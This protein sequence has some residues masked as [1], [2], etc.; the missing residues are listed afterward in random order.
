MHVA[1]HLLASQVIQEGVQHPLQSD[2][3]L[4][5]GSVEFEQLLGV[6]HSADLIIL[7]MHNKQGHLYLPTKTK[8]AGVPLPDVLYK[9]HW[10]C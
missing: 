9:L 6:Q 1:H 2:E 10:L 5:C 4:V 3:L 8:Y 7:P